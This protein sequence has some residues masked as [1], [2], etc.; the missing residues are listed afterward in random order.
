M[1]EVIA[2]LA[3]SYQL[4]QKIRKARRKRILKWTLCS[5]L[6]MGAAGAGTYYLIK[7][8]HKE[9]PNKQNINLFIK[10]LVQNKR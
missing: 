5:L 7:K 3:E 8:H 6:V 4:E 9:E 1:V 2:L 10:D